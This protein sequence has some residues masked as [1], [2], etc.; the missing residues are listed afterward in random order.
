MNNAHPTPQCRYPLR[1]SRVIVIDSDRNFGGAILSASGIDTALLY[2]AYLAEGEDR[3]RVAALYEIPAS[4]VAA[5]V[6][7]ETGSAA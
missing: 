6:A 4:D 5:A 2:Q 1:R 7:F 3:E